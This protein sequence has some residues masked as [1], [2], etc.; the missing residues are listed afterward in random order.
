MQ[1]EPDLSREKRLTVAHSAPRATLASRARRVLVLL[2]LFA[3]TSVAAEMEYRANFV[4]AV[5]SSVLNLGASVFTLRLFFQNGNDLGGWSWPEALVVMGMFTL[6]QGFS[7]ALLQPNL[8]RVVEHVRE[9]TLDFVLL[10]PVDAQL[11]LSARRVSPWGLPDVLLG[12]ALVGYGAHQA[13][14]NSYALGAL[15]VSA[16]CSL[17][18]LYS[19]WF[20]MATTT[21]WFIQIYN[22]TEVLR[23]LLDAGRFPIDAFPAGAY[24]F[25]FT[26][27]VPVAFMTS[28]PARALLGRVGFEWL[29]GA[30]ALAFSLLVA[31][32][33]FFRFALRYYTSA[34][35]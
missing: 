31:T 35:S 11:W 13:S 34:S 14:A 18:I 33:Y 10:K 8:T 12:T 23:A 30:L 9:G 25:V 19:L 27:V 1:R 17:A 32:R 20:L 22:V 29:L 21:V 16:L 3:S 4:F 28:V 24:R 15:V 2:R 5:I 26:F 6:L 7:A